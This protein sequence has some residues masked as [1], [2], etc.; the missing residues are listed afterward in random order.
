MLRPL[1][2]PSTMEEAVIGPGL[3]SLVV[4]VPT[5]CS[6]LKKNLKKIEG[7]TSKDLRFGIA[8][9]VRS[10]PWVTLVSYNIFK[11]LWLEELWIPAKGKPGPSH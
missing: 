6:N 1:T 8:R 4:V 10:I 9:P 11:S 3:N 2:P 5:V 7:L